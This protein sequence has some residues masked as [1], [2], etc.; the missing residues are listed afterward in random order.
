MALNANKM[1]SGFDQKDRVD[2]PE[3]EAGVYPG[4]IVKIVELGLHPQDPY[5][6]VEKPPAQKIL[7][8]YQL[9]DE[10]MLNED[11]EEDETQPRWI[12]EEIPFHPLTSD[13]A[14]STKYY[15][16]LDPEGDQGGSWVGL[17]GTPVG[18]TLTKTEGKGK[19]VGRTF[20]NAK[21]L[22]PLTP[23]VKARL[24]GFVNP[25]KGLYFDRDEAS[26]E[27]FNSLPEYIQ[28]KIKSAL[29]FPASPLKKAL[30]GSDTTTEEE[31]NDE[32]W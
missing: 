26:V 18:V 2:P 10:F 12:S 19:H 25:E 4:Y 8:T 24:N 15:K 23:K 7:I 22:S 13:M 3:L 5:E 9:D 29:D 27:A 32:V 31:S 20:N 1:G 21:G 28:D 30:K 6:G 17:I 14:K 16:V 11:G